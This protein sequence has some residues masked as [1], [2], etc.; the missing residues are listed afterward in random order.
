VWSV[1][2][3]ILTGGVWS[4]GGMILPGENKYCSAAVDTLL[5]MQSVQ[6]WLSHLPESRSSLW[7]N[8]GSG[9]VTYCNIKIGKWDSNI[10]GTIVMLSSSSSFDEDMQ[11]QGNVRNSTA[12]LYGCGFV[13]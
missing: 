3:M 12:V 9:C 7:H 6:K 11:W 13:L 2:G 5:V 8:G 4:V 10:I 1:G